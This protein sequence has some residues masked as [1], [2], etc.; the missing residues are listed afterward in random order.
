M[1]R[2]KVNRVLYFLLP[3]ILV[4]IISL[5]FIVLYKKS[6][7]II[8]I[9]NLLSDGLILFIY[10]I[11]F[12]FEVSMDSEGIN[13]YTLFRKYR[14]KPIDIQEVKQ[15]SFLTKVESK[16]RNLYVLT[17]FKGRYILYDML[18]DIKR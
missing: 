3:T 1:K 12:P 9:I 10:F 16:K 11:K 17:T 2:F 5:Y 13:F 6:Y 8:N 4:L 14:E 15:A 7:T 18:K